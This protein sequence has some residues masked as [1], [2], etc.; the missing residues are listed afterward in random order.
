MRNYVSEVED[1]GNYDEWSRRTPNF[2][3]TFLSVLL[4]YRNDYSRCILDCDVSSVKFELKTKEPFSASCHVHATDGTAVKS[5]YVK[6][7]LIAEF[8]AYFT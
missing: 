6:M 5:Q 3:Y 4:F 7:Q 8:L 1:V 2:S